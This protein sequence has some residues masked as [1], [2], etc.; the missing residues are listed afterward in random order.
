L[1]PAA[2]QGAAVPPSLGRQ[3][4][5]TADSGVKTISAKMADYSGRCGSHAFYQGLTLVR[6]Q[7]AEKELGF[8]V[9][10]RTGKQQVPPLLR[11]PVETDEFFNGHNLFL[12]CGHAE[13]I[14]C[15]ERLPL[16][17]QQEQLSFLESPIDLL[18]LVH[19]LAPD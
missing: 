3:W 12:E 13:R 19:L 11:V 4:N 1:R 6:P 8:R 5:V 18:P 10:V 9:C 14:V 16:F 7:R 15:G 17:E 2:S